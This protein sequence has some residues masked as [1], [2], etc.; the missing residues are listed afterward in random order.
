MR[1]LLAMDGYTG[2]DGV[3]PFVYESK[4]KAIADLTRAIQK[5]EDER[6]TFRAMY[7]GVC[8]RRNE[9]YLEMKQYRIGQE[10]E[11][12][13]EELR[14][15]MA[16]TDLRNFVQ[17]TGKIEFPGLNLNLKDFE[18]DH[19]GYRNLD[20]NPMIQTVDEFFANVE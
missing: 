1:L 14:G 18:F 20:L 12:L 3:V 10:P 19:E 5:A 13:H 17:P 9:I 15:E 4:E 2:F 11:S 8:T 7:A 6:L 16:K